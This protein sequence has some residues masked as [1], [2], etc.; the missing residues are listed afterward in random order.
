MVKHSLQEAIGDLELVAVGPGGKVGLYRNQPTSGKAIYAC[1]DEAG[2][3]LMGGDG[4][5]EEYGYPSPP[6]GGKWRWVPGRQPWAPSAP[7]VTAEAEAA[8]GVGSVPPSGNERNFKSPDTGEHDCTVCGTEDP[9][10][11]QGHAHTR[12]AP[13]GAV[14]VVCCK[15]TTEF[16]AV[17]GVEAVA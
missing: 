8:P 17:C 14:E 5:S 11:K 9:V 13:A 1:A 4:G 12:V 7:A 2:E 15:C 3:T 16:G 10:L 6:A